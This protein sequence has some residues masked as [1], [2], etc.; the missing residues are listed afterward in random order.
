MIIGPSQQT[1]LM[2]AEPMIITQ[3]ELQDAVALTDSQALQSVD[4]TNLSMAQINARASNRNPGD[5]S[6][7]MTE[8]AKSQLTVNPSNINC[9]QQFIEF[10]N[11]T[12]VNP[13][14]DLARSIS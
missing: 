8:T 10:S 2:G 5:D 4:N 7:Q 3:S 11:V 12:P 13:P 1:T 14:T 6:Q 9:Q